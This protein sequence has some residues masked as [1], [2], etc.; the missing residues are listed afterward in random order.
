LESVESRIPLINSAFSKLDFMFKWNF[1][2]YFEE[3]TGIADELGVKVH[4]A[5]LLNF[6]IDVETYCSQI[7]VRQP[8]GTLL[9]SRTVDYGPKD[10][11]RKIIYNAKVMKGDVYLYDAVML[12]GYTGLYTAFKPGAFSYAEN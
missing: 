12:A 3:M 1:P 11:F 5:I 2:V 9:H 4:S 8:D 10:K 6:M 7:I